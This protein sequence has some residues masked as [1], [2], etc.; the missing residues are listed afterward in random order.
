MKKT[1]H[2]LL[3]VLLAT[4]LCVMCTGVQ[5]LAVSGN[6]KDDS[7][8]TDELSSTSTVWCSRPDELQ[9]ILFS[10]NNSI[11]HSADELSEY[12]ATYTYSVEEIQ[13]NTAII[14]LTFTISNGLNSRTISSSGIGGIRELTSDIHLLEANLKESIKF[15]EYCYMVNIGF[16]H[17][18]ERPGAEI[19]LAITP[20]DND[21]PLE[22]LMLMSFGNPVITEDVMQYLPEF[23]QQ[24][25]SVS[26]DQTYDISP[27][28]LG[29]LDV[30]YS[31]VYANFADARSTRAQ[32]LEAALDE[33]SGCIAVALTSLS[34]NAKDVALEEIDDPDAFAMATVSSF[35]IGLEVL[36]GPAY[37]VGVEEMKE[38]NNKVEN[39]VNLISS[40]LG[41]FG[42]PAGTIST[43]INILLESNYSLKVTKEST[44]R[45]KVSSSSIVGLDPFDDAALPV[46]FQTS[47]NGSSNSSDFKATSDITY[48]VQV[49]LIGSDSHAQTFYLSA[50]RAIRLFT[51]DI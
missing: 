42:Y 38:G 48:K 37:I 15:G 46:V 28:V 24:D 6:N 41:D 51:A 23:N 49:V 26:E 11:I 3:S 7:W 4:V 27:L 29:T 14:D 44:N 17:I 8:L 5:A 25:T 40:V 22:G 30:F 2:R 32:K 16:S 13:D 36:S 45:Y 50:D 19:T 9:E 43:L 34:D 31:P 20:T 33:G 35:E 47:D 21:A 18:F 12:T 1:W 39:I 10:R